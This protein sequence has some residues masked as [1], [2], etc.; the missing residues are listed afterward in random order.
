MPT[1]EERATRKVGEIAQMGYDK[2]TAAKIV[3][4]T[5][6]VPGDVGSVSDV[7]MPPPMTEPGAVEEWIY[8][9]ALNYDPRIGQGL[10]PEEAAKMLSQYGFPVD[11]A[12]LGI[13]EPLPAQ[14]V[15]RKPQPKQY[16][17]PP[18][19][20]DIYSGRKPMKQGQ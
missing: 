7:T 8:Q 10:A 5:A 6:S 4:L 18:M 2:Q 15:G 19:A 14:W 20:R 16:E 12:R 3:E 9:Q 11:W 17:P 1:P 13:G